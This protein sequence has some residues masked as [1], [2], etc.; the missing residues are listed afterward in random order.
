MPQSS[1]VCVAGVMI[2]WR[3]SFILSDFRD[4]VMGRDCKTGFAFIF[5]N[6]L[7]NDYKLP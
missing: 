1:A 5:F 7:T 2:K 4:P 3:V 6:K